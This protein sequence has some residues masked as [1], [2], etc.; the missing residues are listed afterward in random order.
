MAYS[1]AC[2]S[3][4]Y[5]VQPPRAPNTSI[6]GSGIILSEIGV[7]QYCGKQCN[8]L[9]LFHITGWFGRPYLADYKAEWGT[10]V[11]ERPPSTILSTQTSN[12]APGCGPLQADLLSCGKASA[13]TFEDKKVSSS[14]FK[15]LQPQGSFIQVKEV[16]NREEATQSRGKVVGLAKEGIYDVTRTSLSG[17]RNCTKHN[18]RCDYMDAPLDED[19]SPDLNITPQVQQELDSWR[20][21]GVSPFPSLGVVDQPSPSRY[22]TTDLRLIHHI[23]SVASQMQTAEPNKYSIWTKRVPIFLRIASHH[24]FVMHSL[25]GLSASHLSW[26][27]ACPATLHL[28]YQHRGSALKGLHEA[29]GNFSK[30]NSD[31]VLAASILLSWQATDWR[32]WASLM[33]GTATVIDAMREWK[34]ESEFGELMDEKEVFSRGPYRPQIADPERDKQILDHVSGALQQLQPYVH[35]KEQETKGLKDLISFIRDLH[36]VLPVNG[37]DQQFELLHPLRSWLFFLPIDFLKR[38]KRDPC[39]MVLLAHFYAVALAVEPLF[40][41]VGA[42]YFGSMSV[43]PIE[44]IYSTL[45]QKA[46]QPNAD[47]LRWSISL[48]EFPLDM[49]SQ[50]RERMSWRILEVNSPDEEK[51]PELAMQ[52]PI[53]SHHE[54][55]PSTRTSLPPLH[56]NLGNFDSNAFTAYGMARSP[57]QSQPSTPTSIGQNISGS[58]AASGFITSVLWRH[59]QD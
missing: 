31:A 2:R 47:D 32:G 59:E 19:L 40:P 43:G 44:E 24:D 6:N 45:K 5:A 48:M 29:I 30:Q 51:D 14:H 38:V 55:G 26:L 18:V 57:A 56:C 54:A 50:F 33:Q 1:K 25:L 15:F 39:V 11:G 16:D 49:I 27:T 41:A 20:S 8:I 34:N 9:K 4:Y 37:P 12:T 21:T 28:A 23:S 22:S 52:I 13:V 53:E 36:S 46:E 10:S 42:N 58:L 17:I 7:K 35:G 3:H